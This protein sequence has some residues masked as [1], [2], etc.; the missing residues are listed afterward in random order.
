MDRRRLRPPDDVQRDGLMSVAAETFDFEIMK[1][2]IQRVTE[3]RGWLRRPL[4]AQ[5][6]H[7][8]SLAGELV[9]FLASFRSA[10]RF[11]PDR[12]AVD[13][14]SGLGGHEA[15]MRLPARDRQAATDCG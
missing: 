4:V 14:F 13:V 5:H 10:L 7:V 9:G 1:A 3:S 2:R 6:P 15:R 12:T 11:R 8:P